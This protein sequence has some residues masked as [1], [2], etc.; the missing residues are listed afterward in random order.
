MNDPACDYQRAFIGPHIRNPI[1]KG[2][3]VEVEQSRA[4]DGIFCHRP[5]YTVCQSFV[6]LL[7]HCVET[8]HPGHAV[9]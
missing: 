8:N 6:G 9:G 2:K 5:G 1:Q 7:H 4:G 3:P